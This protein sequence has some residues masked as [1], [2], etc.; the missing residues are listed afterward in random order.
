[1]NAIS[2]AGYFIVTLGTVLG[3]LSIVACGI[4]ILRSGVVR[5][6]REA[7]EGWEKRA[8]LLS[9][10]LEDC[11]AEVQ[12]A[13]EQHT[14]ELA[15]LRAELASAR[16]RISVLEERTDLE[17]VRALMAHHNEEA[18]A[19]HEGIVSALTALN[20]QIRGRAG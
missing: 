7:S 2:L 3:M 4:V 10:N 15:E 20:V 19:R 11:H 17:P 18:L 1:M 12:H 6:L 14:A 8:D 16:E 13:T 5:G 9:S